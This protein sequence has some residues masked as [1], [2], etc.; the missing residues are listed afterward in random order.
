MDRRCVFP[1]LQTTALQSDAGL[2]ASGPGACRRKK[3][4]ADS[5]ITASFKSSISERDEDGSSQGYVHGALGGPCELDPLQR[6]TDQNPRE[7]NQHGHRDAHS[8]LHQAIEPAVSWFD[9]C[10]R[11]KQGSEGKIDLRIG[12]TECEAASQRETETA[13]G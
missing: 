13:L 7:I 2:M 12:G 5:L 9:D 11:T 8:P 6:H 10:E 3:I 4:W 1:A